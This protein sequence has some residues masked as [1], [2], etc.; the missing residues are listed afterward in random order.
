MKKESKNKLGIITIFAIAMAFIETTVVVYLR[1]LYYGGGF[2]FPLK[3]FIEPNIL[4]IEWVREFGTIIMLLAIGV[5]AGKK[6]YEKLAY[7]ILAFSIWDIFYYVFLKVLLNWPSS[8]LTWDIL[9]LIPLPWISP[10]LAP[11]I[12]CVILMALAISIIYFNDKGHNVKISLKE[13]TLLIFGMLL[14][15]YTWLYDY[16]K[17]IFSEG[18]GKE[19]FSLV[20][21]AELYSVISSYVPQVYNWTV[22]W[23]G[24]LSASLG[25]FFFFRRNSKKK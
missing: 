5:L 8:F 15:L 1:E 10:V 16:S 3:G 9:F 21:N 4:A 12:C 14:V 11:L 24:I 20:E 6:M 22:F 13:W 2:D 7:F 23:V 19:F 18:F 25:V 17:L